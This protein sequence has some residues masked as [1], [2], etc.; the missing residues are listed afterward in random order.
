MA[1]GQPKAVAKRPKGAAAAAAA[2][3]NRGPRKGGRT[4]APKKLRVVQQQK[5][6]K[7]LEVGIRMRIERETVQRAQGSLPKQLAL[8]TAPA[9]S[10]DRAKKGRG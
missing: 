1:Q 5:L 2:R 7:R 6:K 9:P 10:K 4:I 8:V 3:G